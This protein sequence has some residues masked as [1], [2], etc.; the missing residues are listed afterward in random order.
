MHT[1]RYTIFAVALAG[2]ACLLLAAASTSQALTAKQ[3]VGRSLFIDTTLSEPAGQACAACHAGNVGWTGPDASVNLKGAVY[4]GAFPGRFGNR[5]PPAAAYAGYSP[6]LH[7]VNSTTGWVGGMFWDG[8]KT[9][10]VLGDPLTE[11][12]QG[13]FLNP[14]EQNN[15]DAAAVVAK[16]K[17]SSYA[18]LFKA[19]WGAY[20]FSDTNAAYYAIAQSIATFERS[21]RVSS[22]SS[23]YDARRA[24]HA[25]FTAREKQGMKLFNGKA[26]CSNCHVAR[27]FTD[28]SYDNLGIP[29]NPDN[30]FY[31]EPAVNPAGAAWVDE[32][33]GGYLK[34]SGF[35][36]A[37]ISTPQLGKFKVPTL[38]NVDK[39][40]SP[41]F[42]KA[43][44]H[45]GYFKSLREI[46]HFYNTR[47]VA[48]AGW[49][50][51]PWPAPEYAATVNTSEIGNLGLTATQEKAIVAFLKTLTDR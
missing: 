18:P 13:P 45:N 48:G 31:N 21:P 29:K 28:Y 47:D 40:P 22:F 24:G 23:K 12:A 4:P 36:D 20:I 10:Y 11:Q 35:Y 51:V 5:K 6:R 43:Y 1:R 46:V 49:K 3:K 37:S 19:V 33:L 34:A 25:T 39:R 38:R 30:P 9:G 27:L 32:G 44:G 26:N 17:V 42:V 50:G 41:S 14:L 8:R 15:A 2:L 16:V 7:Y